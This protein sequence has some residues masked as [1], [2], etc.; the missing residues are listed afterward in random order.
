MTFGVARQVPEPERTVVGPER[1]SPSTRIADLEVADALVALSSEPR[2]P[3]RTARLLSTN[4]S[5]DAGALKA[6]ERLIIVASTVPSVSRAE[7]AADE[8]ASSRMHRAFRSRSGTE[9]GEIPRV[10]GP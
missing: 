5:C 3:A 9:L 4:S 10:V 1:A 8:R 2:S 7:V 6:K